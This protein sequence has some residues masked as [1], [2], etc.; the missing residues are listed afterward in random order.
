VLCYLVDDLDHCERLP[1]LSKLYAE[2]PVHLCS[3]CQCS[4]GGS[5]VSPRAR[6]NR[7]WMA[8]QQ[9]LGPI[10]ASRRTTQ[11]QMWRVEGVTKWSPLKGVV[12]VY[13][14]LLHSNGNNA[15][16]RSRQNASQ[17]VK[18]RDSTS[19]S[20]LCKAETQAGTTSVHPLYLNAEKT[21][22]H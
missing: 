18:A 8:K 16:P 15:A 14:G 19:P 9:D 13:T 6:R 3:F 21:G 20:H 12:G 11:G 4:P 2:L 10:G 22:S 7:C 1:Q 5:S 17:R